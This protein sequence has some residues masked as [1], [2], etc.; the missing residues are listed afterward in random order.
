MKGLNVDGCGIAVVRPNTCGISSIIAGFFSLQ[1]LKF[2]SKIKKNDPLLVEIG[3]YF[4]FFLHY[5]TRLYSPSVCSNQSVPDSPEIPNE[6]QWWQN[7]PLTGRSLEQ[8]QDCPLL[9]LLDQNST[10][11]WSINI[12]HVSK[13]QT[14]MCCRASDRQSLVW[15]LVI[16]SKEDDTVLCVYT[17]R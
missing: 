16:G 2:T 13:T 6:H 15:L 10:T 8:D 12:Q 1:S 4:N 11:G 9:T 3:R 5:M 17:S 7:L 14:R